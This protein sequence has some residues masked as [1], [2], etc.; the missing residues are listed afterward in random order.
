MRKIRL[1]PDFPDQL[2]WFEGDGP[3]PPEELG[4]SSE[5]CQQLRDWYKW[6]SRIA[7]DDEYRG[8]ETARIDWGFFDAKGIDLWKKLRAELVDRYEVVFYSHRLNDDFDV[9][10]ELEILLRH[11][12]IA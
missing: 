4:L 11:D 3:V 7:N 2:L 10:S 12:P 6:W 9:P 8:D 1:V 5:L